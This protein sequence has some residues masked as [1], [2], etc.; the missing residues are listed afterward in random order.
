MIHL[1]K[2]IRYVMQ[3]K[4]WEVLHMAKVC[5]ICGKGKMTGNN[6]SHA[7]NRNKRTW[8]PN[9]KKVRAIVDGSTK[10]INVCTSCIKSGKVE[11]AY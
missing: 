8:K 6:V 3:L 1:L 9:I 2:C 11:K 5:E 4:H 7:K 10:R